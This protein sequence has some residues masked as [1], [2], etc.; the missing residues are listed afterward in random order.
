MKA[1]LHIGTEKTGTTTIQNFLAKNR[2]HLLEDGYLYPSSPG[3]TNHIK[4]AILAMKSSKIQYIHKI[5][6]LKTPKQVTKFQSQF[7]KNFTRELSLAD[8]QTVILSNEHC[9]SQLIL[10]EDIERLKTFLNN[11]FEDIKIII[12]LR[13]QDKY[14]ASLYSTAIQCGHSEPFNLPSKDTLQRRY[15]YYYILK[16]WESVFGKDNIIVKIFERHQ[17]LE[18]NLLTDFTNA[19][20]IKLDN[21]YE[22]L[23]NLNQSLDIYSLEY[24][25]II[26]L[27]FKLFV[28][29]DPSH[30]RYRKKIVQ[31]LLPYLQKYSKGNKLLISET[32]AKNFMFNFYES[33]KQVAR[34]FLDRSDGNLFSED[35]TVL[36]RE[37]ISQF[38]TFKKL[39][40]I[41]IFLF[42]EKLKTKL[43]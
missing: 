37:V 21:R 31:S 20:D 14:L 38:T 29:D 40:E 16:E 4:L 5:F 1:F 34:D 12:Y 8:F 22:L 6:D 15:N 9:S 28:K 7:K 33:N 23:P 42:K 3:Q 26:N 27:C 36:K 2:K 17:M 11:F 39:F 32:M 43:H 41:T 10:K 24:L 13:R 18:G 30:N 35:F 19:L 25:R